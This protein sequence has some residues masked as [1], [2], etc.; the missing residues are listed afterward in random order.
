[1]KSA[2]SRGNTRIPAGFWPPSGTDSPPAD[3]LHLQFRPIVG[4]AG[5]PIAAMH[6]RIDAD[7]DDDQVLR[8]DRALHHMPV[9]ADDLARRLPGAES[10]ADFES[11]PRTSLVRI[12]SGC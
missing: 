5:D 4:H 12:N 11:A 9:D 8:R 10:A 3:G 7:R 1:M 6:H 2:P